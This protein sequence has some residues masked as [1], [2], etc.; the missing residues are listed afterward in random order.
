[1]SIRASLVHVA[2]RR[3]KR[4]IKET[5]LKTRGEAQ[6]VSSGWLII[7]PDRSFGLD[8][9]MTLSPYSTVKTPLPDF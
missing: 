1:M 7:S 3:G 5:R 2:I 8:T 4:K 9:W 6:L